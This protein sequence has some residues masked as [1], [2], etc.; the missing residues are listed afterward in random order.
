LTNTLYKKIDPKG[1]WYKQKEETKDMGIKVAS[2]IPDKGD[3]NY[4][5]K[6]DLYDPY[7]RD[8]ILGAGGHISDWKTEENTDNTLI[9][10]GLGGTSQ[11]A[12]KQCM[13][14]GRDFFAIDT[15]YMQ[16][17]KRKDYHRV[18]KNALQNLGPIIPRDTDR[19]RKLGWRWRKPDRFP[20]DGKYILVCPPSEKVMKF[21]GESLDEWMKTTIE[22]IKLNTDCP[23]KIRLKPSREDRVNNDTICDALEGAR[24]L[25]TYN[26]I[27]AT[28]A[29]LYSKPA[30]AL[31]PNAATVLCNTSIDEINNLT[32]PT[33]EELHAFAAH[34]SYCQFTAQEMVDGTAWRILNE[35]S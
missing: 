29:L 26:S 15:G 2:I 22:Q 12:L 3:F 28:E 4:D 24:C 16:P 17:A 7:C 32:I 31:A 20:T 33:K 5:K 25:V 19:L 6:G 1:K 21:Y 30:I 34:L 10:R 13:E 11:K 35:S 23:I 9:I 18:T 27:A 8:L 14:L